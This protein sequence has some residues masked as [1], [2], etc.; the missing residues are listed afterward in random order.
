M[1]RKLPI[2]VKLCY[3]AGSLG[4][5]VQGLAGSTFLLY[6]YTE[7]LGV[8]PG[9]AGSIIFFGK[10]FD[11]IN[12]PLIGAVV[13]K[14]HSKD[15]MCRTYLKYYAVPTGICLFLCF[16]SPGFSMT[17]KII[18]IALT[19]GI[20][21][22]ASSF[23]QIPMNTLMGRLTTDGQQRAHLNQISGIVS[24]GANFIVVSWTLPAAVFFGG[25]DMQKGFAF[26][27]LSYGILYALSY[28]IVFWGTRGYEQT[29]ASGRTPEQREP[30]A[31]LRQIV[32]ALLQNK[33]WLCI[34]LYYLFDMIATT[35]ESTAMV[36][37]FQYNL[38]DTGLLSAYS[39]VAMICNGVIFATL[40]LFTRRLGNA[41]ATLLG[42]AVSMSG[43]LL[44]FLFHD[45]SFTVMAAG[46]TL[47]ALGSC[48]V[49]GTVLLN[50]FD[51]KTYGEWKTGIK[52]EAVL[53]SGFTLATKIGMALGSAMIGWLLALFPY[54]E[55]AQT[56]PQPVLDLFFTANTL[57][58][59]I[60]FLLVLILTIPVY[61]AEKRLPQMRRE[62]EKREK[63][64]KL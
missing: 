52:S 42:C 31:S 37:Y 36:Y 19:Y 26:V 35:L 20:L 10:L 1:D 50:L 54:T 21:A 61:R 43:D 17:G 16:L 34:G 63:R 55:G 13:D 48:L 47:S 60:A 51:A 41:G 22:T 39:A 30:D 2:H 23:I 44:R 24:L 4:K 33:I 57:V 58:P 12:D 9:L 32:S 38:G 64:K 49:A 14:T 8:A 27:G 5:V 15:G 25:G 46:W 56:Q 53:M 3:G 11:I 45:S 59:A 6:F 18:W 62:L 7:I 40:H 29:E 28:L